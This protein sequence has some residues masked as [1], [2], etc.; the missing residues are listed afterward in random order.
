MFFLN[1]RKPDSKELI[2]LILSEDWP[3]NLKKIHSNLKRSGKNIS[4]QA[5]HKTVKCLLGAGILKKIGLEYRLSTAWLQKMELFCNDINNRYAAK[6][7][8]SVDCSEF[9]DSYFSPLHTNLVFRAN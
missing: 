1:G 7:D 9:D 6:E 8:Y 5:V 2:V 3:L 4:Y